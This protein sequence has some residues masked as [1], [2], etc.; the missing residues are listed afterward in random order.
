MNDGW[1]PVNERLPEADKMPETD[2]ECPEFN[3]TIWGAKEATTL[4]YSPIDDTWFDDNGNIYPIIAW[5]P[6][7]EPYQPKSK[8]PEEQQE[9]KERMLRNFLRGHV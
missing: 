5:R 7:P 6:L 4:K 1:I 2:T 9:W 8:T 3:V